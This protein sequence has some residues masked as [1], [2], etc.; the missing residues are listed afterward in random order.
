M[1][2]IGE[3]CVGDPAKYKREVDESREPQGPT[4]QPSWDKYEAD[5]SRVTGDKTEK[6]GKYWW[7][8]EK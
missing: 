1:R 2:D 3:M 5:G 8:F 7:V 4:L 6:I